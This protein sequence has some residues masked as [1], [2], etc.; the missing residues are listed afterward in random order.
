MPRVNRLDPGQMAPSTA[1]RDALRNSVP[2]EVA[3]LNLAY[4]YDF[5]TYCATE[6]RRPMPASVDTVC[7]YVIA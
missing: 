1:V 3:D 7:R 6:Q 5:M 4:W 2:K